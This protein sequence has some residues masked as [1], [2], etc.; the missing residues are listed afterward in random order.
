MTNFNTP[1]PCRERDVTSPLSFPYCNGN[2]HWDGIGNSN[3]D[4]DVSQH[5]TL[6]LRHAYIISR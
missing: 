5:T 3:G 1:L 2:A 6:T 4:G